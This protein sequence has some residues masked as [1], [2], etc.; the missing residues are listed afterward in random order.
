MLIITD[1][2]E[3]SFGTAIFLD[4][5]TPKSKDLDSSH[6][7]SNRKKMAETMIQSQLIL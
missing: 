1:S 7:N 6:S 4:G 3:H 2:G 5:M